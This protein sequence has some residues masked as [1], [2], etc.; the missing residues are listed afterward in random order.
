MTALQKEKLEATFQ[1]YNSH[2]LNFMSNKQLIR[3]IL[4][5]H[6]LHEQQ[7]YDNIDMNMT[8]LYYNVIVLSKKHFLLFEHT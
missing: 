4:V 1:F 5:H 3:R 6:A 2:Q 7:K 8:I